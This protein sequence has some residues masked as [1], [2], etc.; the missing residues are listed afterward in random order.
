MRATAR[1]A[2][3]ARN[4]V[5]KLLV[6]AGWGLAELQDRMYRNLDCSRIEADEVWC[7]VYARTKTQAAHPEAGDVWL[8][9][10]ICADTRFVMSWWLGARNTE[11]CERFV[12]DIDRR[13]AGPYQ[14][15]TDHW[16]AYPPAVKDRDWIT[17]QPAYKHEGLTTAHIER[18]YGT[19][20]LSVKRYNRSTLAFSKKLENHAHAVALHFMHYNFSHWHK[21]LKK[22]PAMAEGLADHQWTPLEIA[23]H[24]P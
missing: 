21:T 6:D 10:A 23:Q 9:V 5:T 12:D 15:F 14:M 17:H 7:F 2:G 24:V 4:T 1:T 16:I 20:R 8:W 3:V 11:A 19:L 18:L 13:L 22:T